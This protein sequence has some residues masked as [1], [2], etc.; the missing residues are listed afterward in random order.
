MMLMLKCSTTE[1]FEGGID[2]KEYEGVLRVPWI[3]Y[4]MLVCPNSSSLSVCLS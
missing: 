2:K 1:C 3:A 4:A